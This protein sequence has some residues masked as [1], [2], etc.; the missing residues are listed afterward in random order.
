MAI[1]LHT[2]LDYYWRA[3]NQR[4]H[5]AQS[6]GSRAYL[7]NQGRRKCDEEEVRYTQDG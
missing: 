3:Q 5:D 7:G 2:P 6:L 4:C 1:S